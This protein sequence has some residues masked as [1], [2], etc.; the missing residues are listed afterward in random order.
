MFSHLLKESRA[1]SVKFIMIVGMKPGLDMGVSRIVFFNSLLR[2]NP[3]HK[4]KMLNKAFCIAGVKSC[5]ITQ[6]T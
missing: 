5:E 6:K 4:T 1:N 3:F 2:F